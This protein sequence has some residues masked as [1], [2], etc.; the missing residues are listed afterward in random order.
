MTTKPCLV[1]LWL[2]RFLGVVNILTTVIQDRVQELQ[3]INSN[4]KRGSPISL[5][6]F[7]CR[8]SIL[9]ESVGIWNVGFCGGR[10]T[11]VSGEKP[12]EQG[13]NQQQT[14]TTYNTG[15]ESNLSDINGRRAF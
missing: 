4:I 13:D 14:Q 1:V 10:K 5:S 9:I 3:E 11:G 12:T 15:T 8:S 7:P 2:F 6:W